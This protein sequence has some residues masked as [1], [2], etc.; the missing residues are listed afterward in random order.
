MVIKLEV[1]QRQAAFKAVTA[2]YPLKYAKPLRDALLE[3]RELTD[4]ERAKIKN[5]VEIEETKTSSMIEATILRQLIAL[6]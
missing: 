1:A 6:L 4:E 3:N 5:A 2:H